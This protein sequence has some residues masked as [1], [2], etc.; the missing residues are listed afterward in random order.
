[1]T[2]I[3]LWITDAC[4][5]PILIYN[6]YINNDIAAKAA[7]VKI[8]SNFYKMKK[9]NKGFTLIELLVV[10]AII[11]ILGAI[12]LATLGSARNKGTDAAI[13]SNLNNARAQAELFASN[14]SNSYSGVCAAGP[15]AVN[16][17][18][19][20]MRNGATSAGS[21]A[22]GCTDSSGN[23]ILYAQL[24]GTV[25]TTYYCVDSSGRSTSTI[26]TTVTTATLCP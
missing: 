2:K 3:R 5:I 25:L 18:I 24:K 9:T 26:S 15:T 14:N 6:T 23:W 12:T 21:A 4:I 17:G 19:L 1:M 11:G 7:K 22:T 16:P 10:I 13:Q 8:I 20:A